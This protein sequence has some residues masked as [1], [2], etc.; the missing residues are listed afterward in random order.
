MATG[1]AYEPQLERFDV[2][3]RAAVLVARGKVQGAGMMRKQLGMTSLHCSEIQEAAFELDTIQQEDNL[4]A[5]LKRCPYLLTYAMELLRLY[6]EKY[7]PSRAYH[8]R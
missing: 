2:A 3:M 6:A 7:A 4:F 8:Y 1:E 5:L